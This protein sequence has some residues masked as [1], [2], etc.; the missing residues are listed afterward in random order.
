MTASLPHSVPLSIPNS[1]ASTVIA[2]ADGNYMIAWTE[3]DGP[4][5][6]ASVFTQI[7]NPAGQVLRGKEL[8]YQKQGTDFTDLDGVTLADGSTVLVWYDGLISKIEATFFNP[9]HALIPGNPVT[10]S[11]S[12]ASSPSLYKVGATADGGFTVLYKGSVPSPG[13]TN[14]QSYLIEA[15][16]SKSAT[17]WAPESFTVHSSP[18]LEGSGM[19]TAGLPNGNVILLLAT[20]DSTIQAY[21]YNATADQVVANWTAGNFASGSNVHMG[22]SALSDGGIVAVWEDKTPAG[23]KVMHLQAFNASRQPVGVAVDFPIPALTI[24]GSPQVVPLANGGFALSFEVRIAANDTDVYVAACAANGTIT[25]DAVTVGTVTAGDQH[26]PS[27]TALSNGTF[28]VSW[29]D[30]DRFSFETEIFGA[31][32]APSTPSTP[33]WSGTQGNDVYTGT[34]GD[35]FLSGL[36][37]SD[38]LYGGAG[39]DQ[40]AGDAGND[41]LDGGDGADI[42]R[43]GLGKD[44]LSGGA[45]ADSFY[46]DSAVAKKKNANIDKI[47]KF[48]VKDDTIYLAKSIFTKLK[49]GKLK[50]DAFFIGNKAH[51]GSDRIVYDKKSGKLFYDADGTGK[52]QPIQFATLDKNLKMTEKDFFVV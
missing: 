35:D 4:T 30:S 38:K 11:D 26:T 16:V 48:N 10:I 28:I 5:Q 33:T 42:L 18:H 34:A 36:G 21:E 27:L 49:V 31:A 17:G 23:A 13:Q 14:S 51:D 2:L 15:V 43:G 45:G 25:Q 9:S 8:A 39:N 40:L 7:M 6:V 19:V 20:A 3:T 32:G 47:V 29:R 12:D 50:K 24:E 46:F 37:G 44:T 52:Q 22:V 41:L 1:F